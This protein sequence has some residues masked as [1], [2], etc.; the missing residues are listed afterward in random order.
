VVD[1]SPRDESQTDGAEVEGTPKVDVVEV[2][3]EIVYC[4]A[5][6][7]DEQR[8]VRIVTGESAPGLG[9]VNQRTPLAESLLGRETGDRVKVSLPMGV[10]RY[11]ILE[12]VK[13]RR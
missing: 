13:V 3:D 6:K 8:K 10:D 11:E 7:P 1:D 4:I 2:G 12:I 9:T 5:G